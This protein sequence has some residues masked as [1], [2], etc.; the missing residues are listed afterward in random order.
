M[1]PT[2]RPAGAADWPLP[3]HH[4]SVASL[5]RRH[6]HVYLLSAP[7]RPRVAIKEGSFT[8]TTPRTRVSSQRSAAPRPLRPL[9]PWARRPAC[10]RGCARPAPAPSPEAPTMSGHYEWSLS[11]HECGTYLHQRRAKK[12]RLHRCLRSGSGAGLGS[13]ITQE[14]ERSGT[15]V[16]L[17]LRLKVLGPSERGGAPGRGGA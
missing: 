12:L 4:R 17:K 7:P 10:L 8:P 6:G 2:G 3:S 1:R 5:R 11:G 14:R 15:Q 13:G 16:G 9:R